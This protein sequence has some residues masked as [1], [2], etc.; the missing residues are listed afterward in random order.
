MGVKGKYYTYMD[1]LPFVKI[2][3][4]DKMYHFDKTFNSLFLVIWS[5]SD[6]VAILAWGF[7]IAVIF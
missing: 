3:L 2:C 7:F 5:N 1:L 6:C 4:V